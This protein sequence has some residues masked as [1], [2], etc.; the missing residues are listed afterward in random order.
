MTATD[1]Y[2]TLVK[3]YDRLDSVIGFYRQYVEYPSFLRA[4]GPV[5]GG[6]ILDV[7]CGEGAFTRLIA[8]ELGASEVVGVDR[9][10]GMIERARQI[11]AERPLGITYQVHD[12]ATMP[13]QDG[14]DA[15]TAAYVLH[16]AGSRETLEMMAERLFASVIPGGRLIA[17]LGNTNSTARSEEAC[18]FRI[19]RPEHPHEGQEYA[20]SILTDPPT[21][22]YVRYWPTNTVI[23]VLVSAGFIDV[24]CEAFEVSP[25][26]PA[27]G[28][29]R[30]QRCVENPT[31]VLLTA[32][33]SPH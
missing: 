14:F 33:T 28:R 19:H 11:E 4:V 31:G 17:I 23:D 6:R 25:S 32:G 22:F 13:V 30:A 18:G 3:S 21:D 7:G 27:G 1:Q 5:P 29:E 12:L 9:S 2:E 26:T 24:R 10:P 8:A 16:Y 20:L 15:V